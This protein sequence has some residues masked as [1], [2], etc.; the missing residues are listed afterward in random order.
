MNKISFEHFFIE[1]KDLLTESLYRKL[2]PNTMAFFKSGDVYL[3]LMNQY[4][5]L[6]IAMAVGKGDTFMHDI[7]KECRKFNFG[8]VKFITSV[9]NTRVQTLAK[10][11]HAQEVGREKDY[12]GP[13]EDGIEYEIN[14]SDKN[15][16]MLRV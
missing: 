15:P 11:W 13:G 1:T 7:L 12:Y 2:N 3:A 9:K 5:T 10:Y 14:I 4:D 8:F 16:R 6:I